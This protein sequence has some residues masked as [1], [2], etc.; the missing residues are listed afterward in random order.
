MRPSSQLISSSHM[1]PTDTPKA[2][3]AIAIA[4]HLGLE[5]LA[6]DIAPSAVEAAELW[7]LLSSQKPHP[8]LTTGTPIDY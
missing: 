1:H 7:D 2:Y 6:I 8:K 4:R 3:D 5:T